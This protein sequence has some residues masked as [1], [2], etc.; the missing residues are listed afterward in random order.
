MAKGSIRIQTSPVD[1][2]G[3]CRWI[4]D[5][6]EGMRL[7]LCPSNTLARL[8]EVGHRR[9]SSAAQF[10]LPTPQLAFDHV[11][12]MSVAFSNWVQ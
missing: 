12:W 3:A 2:K 10:P 9:A 4:S 7:P 5:W 8:D 11:P 6:W 1:A